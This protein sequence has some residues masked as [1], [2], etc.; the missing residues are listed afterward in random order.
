[1]GRQLGVSLGCVGKVQAD[2]ILQHLVWVDQDGTCFGRLEIAFALR[3][4]K[5]NGIGP[6][7]RV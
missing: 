6:N 5:A 3:A 1:M 2:G 7:G 4:V